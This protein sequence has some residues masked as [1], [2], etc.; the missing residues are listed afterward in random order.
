MILSFRRALERLKFLVLFAVFTY[1]LY[2]LF[3]YVSAWVGPDKYR[4]PE[5]KA[6][7]AF[8]SSDTVPGFDHETF[9]DRLRFFYWYGE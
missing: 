8:N 9:K 1:V 7:K 2:H 5:G 6:V 4:E 3:G